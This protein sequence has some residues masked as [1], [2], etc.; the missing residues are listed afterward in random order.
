MPQGDQKEHLEE[1]PAVAAFF[2]PYEN[3]RAFAL[4]KK[5]NGNSVPF[6]FRI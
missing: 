6:L 1:L 5:G 4:K 3:N 2:I